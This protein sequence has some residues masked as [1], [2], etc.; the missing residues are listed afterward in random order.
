L[1]SSAPITRNPPSYGFPQHAGDPYCNTKWDSGLGI[2]G[3]E[4]W[5]LQYQMKGIEWT[6][7]DGKITSSAEMF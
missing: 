3:I 2:T 4:V 5:A 6:Y 7:S 1:C